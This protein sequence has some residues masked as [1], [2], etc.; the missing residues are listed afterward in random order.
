MLSDLTDQSTARPAGMTFS[1][2]TGCLTLTERQVDVRSE[3]LVCWRLYV[4]SGHVAEDGVTTLFLDIDKRPM[5][6]VMSLL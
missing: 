2:A 3:C 4:K 1:L 5:V 6:A